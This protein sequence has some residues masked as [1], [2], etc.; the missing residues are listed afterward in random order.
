[1]K[2]RGEQSKFHIM[3]GGRELSKAEKGQIAEAA[4]LFRL[5]LHGL[6]V[7]TGVFDG[8]RVDWL[9]EVPSGKLARLQV[10]WARR[11]K[12]GLPVFYLTCSDGRGRTRRYQ[13]GEFDFLVG[14]DLFTDTAYVYSWKELSA[15]VDSISVR[16]DAAE[17]WDKIIGS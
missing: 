11:K 15:N 3:L 12:H 17:R 14:Y 1:M 8:G 9:V 7:L 4:V 10:K 2:P 13:E 16:P 5:V 6:Q